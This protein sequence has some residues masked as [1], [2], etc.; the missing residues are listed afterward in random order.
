MIKLV[1]NA[2]LL[3]YL[4]KEIEQMEKLDS[5]SDSLKLLSC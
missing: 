2:F 5:L 4:D 1:Y 3:A